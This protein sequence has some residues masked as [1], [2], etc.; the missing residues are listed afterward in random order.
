M[1]DFMTRKERA[2]EVLR[3]SEGQGKR[4][5]DDEHKSNRLNEQISQLMN[6][7]EQARESAFR[8]SNTME[9]YHGR[10]RRDV[11]KRCLQLLVRVALSQQ[12][13]MKA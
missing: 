8:L 13:K 4:T 6:V 10:D 5:H 2:E 7:T 12:M 9:G 1:I 3:Q 11:Q